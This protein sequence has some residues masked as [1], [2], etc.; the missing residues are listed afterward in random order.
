[1]THITLDPKPGATFTVNSETFTL[2][3]RL[4]YQADLA[5]FFACTFD[6]PLATT[7]HGG[8]RFDRVLEDD[9]SMVN[10]VLKVVSNPLDNDLAENE[11]EV[12]THLFPPK[13]P[14]EKFYRYL[15]QPLASFKIRSGG[16][17]RQ[18]LVMPFMEGYY[19]MAEV[20][21]AFPKGLDFRDVV[22][23]F[24]RLLVGI[25]FAHTREVVHGAIVPAH[26]LVHPV[27]HGAKVIDWSYAV[28]GEGR[29]RAMSLAY[30]DFYAPEILEKRQP[31]GATDIFMAAKCAVQLLGGDSKTNQMPDAVPKEIQAFLLDL[32][33]P[34]PNMRP[35]D[36]WDLHE[37]FDKLLVKLVGKPTYRPL[38]MP[39]R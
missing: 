3:N 16:Q 26:V 10:A 35:Q 30:E 27:G 8:T 11:V 7:N 9:V 14:D 31:K 22:W 34:L 25:G 2:G 4:P 23:M 39:A 33:N 19:S 28:R 38:S 12:L 21:R 1:M 13:A 29:V 18:A 20:Y 15:P 37:A 5:E 6:K 36:A 32:L 24:K 17:E